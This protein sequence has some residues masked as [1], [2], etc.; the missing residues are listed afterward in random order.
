VAVLVTSGGDGP[1]AI[2]VSALRRAGDD[3][4][5]LALAHSRRSL[6]RL[7]DQ[8]RVA[9][10]LIGA[11]FSVTAQG[12]ARVVAEPLPG[13]E[14]M[15]AVQVR[16]ERLESTLGERTVI[17]A[18]VAWGWRDDEFD[19]HHRQVLAALDALV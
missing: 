7:R 1:W 5:L 14:F 11:G 13:A 9:L 4:V 10:T 6:A 12:P 16:A 15:T 17:H 18:G 19:A 2:P 3:R 8:P